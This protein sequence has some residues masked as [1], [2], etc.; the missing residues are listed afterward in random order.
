MTLLDTTTKPHFSRDEVEQLLERAYQAGI[1][2]GYMLAVQ[3]EVLELQAM[4]HQQE[5]EALI[6]SHEALSCGQR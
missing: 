3:E 2:E 1:N 6:A 5:I 4:K